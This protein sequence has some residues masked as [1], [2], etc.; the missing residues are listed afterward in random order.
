MTFLVDAVDHFT[1]LDKTYSQIAGGI[2]FYAKKDLPTLVKNKA[3]ATGLLC[4]NHGTSDTKQTSSDATVNAMIAACLTAS[5][6]R[7]GADR[8]LLLR[9][10]TT[11]RTT[12]GRV[13]AVG[14]H[15]GRVRCT[16]DRNG[17]G[18]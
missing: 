8:R 17:D 5:S 18:R 3:L 4:T 2:S 13:G 16:S 1:F 15:F 10:R 9:P 11:L 12:L 6:A 7:R 14:V